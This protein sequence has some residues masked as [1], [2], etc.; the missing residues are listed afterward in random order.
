MQ[1]H[2]PRGPTAGMGHEGAL[3]ALSRW[4]CRAE[5]CQAWEQPLK[6]PFSLCI[7]LSTTAFLPGSPGLAS[8]PTLSLSARLY[9][10][11]W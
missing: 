4:G 8:S 1:P 9:P 11:P 2:R 3:P 5:S 10:H 7:W 6:G